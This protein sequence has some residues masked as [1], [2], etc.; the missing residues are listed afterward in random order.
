M[1]AAPQLPEI[2]GERCVHALSPVASCRACVDACPVSAWILDDEGLSLNTSAC[3]GCG[4]C[5]PVCPREAVHLD[6][7]LFVCRSGPREAAAFAAC[8]RS[9]ATSASL[10]CLHALGPADLDRLAV[11]KVRRLTVASGDCATC[12]LGAGREHLGDAARRHAAIRDGQGQP[13]IALVNLSAPA[14]DIALAQARQ[15][16]EQVDDRRRRLFAPLLGAAEPA[17]AQPAPAVGLAYWRPL[18][19]PVRC[20]ACDACVR[21]CP[22]G[23]LLRDNGRAPAYRSDPAR[24]SGCRLCIDSC[25]HGAVA[26]VPLQSAAAQRLPLDPNKCK[27]CGNTYY[28]LAGGSDGGGQSLCR[29]C[30]RTG[31]YKKLFQVLKDP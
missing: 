29:I 13:A 17:T 2:D 6:R 30:A 15:A 12:D 10:A 4:L 19:D 21:I 24:C 31:H 1:D 25:D 9:G 8:T 7:N 22:D 27:A 20:V 28:V 18:I 3:T 26:V 11:E 5:V 16:S 23:A 14:F